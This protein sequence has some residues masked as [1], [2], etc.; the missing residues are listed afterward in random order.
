MIDVH[1]GLVGEVAAGFQNS[2]EWYRKPGRYCLCDR[3]RASRQ[4]REEQK[5]NSVFCSYCI[6]R[7]P[8]MLCLLFKTKQA[9]PQLFPTVAR[10]IK[11]NDVNNQV[12]C[13]HGDLTRVVFSIPADSQLAKTMSTA[14]FSVI[15]VGV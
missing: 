13:C 3:V 11:C 5:G 4:G 7:K 12:H 9:L 15:V 1:R 2:E 10:N 8:G 14:I 6:P